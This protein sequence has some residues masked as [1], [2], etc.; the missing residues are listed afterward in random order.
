MG[1]LFNRWMDNYCKTD[2]KPTT[3]ES[4]EVHVR[5]HLKP[6]APL[7]LQDPSKLNILEWKTAEVKKGAVPPVH[8]LLALDSQGSAE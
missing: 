3:W 6:L 2:L 4:Y 8:R 1:D 5:L 7:K